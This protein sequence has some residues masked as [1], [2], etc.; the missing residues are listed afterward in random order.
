[1]PTR[2]VRLA[3]VRSGWL[4]PLLLLLFAGA[5]IASAQD[6]NA[7]LH[8]P[9]HTSRSSASLDPKLLRLKWNAPEGFS[10]PLIIGDT[11]Y[12]V[13]FRNSGTGVGDVA[14]FD[15]ESGAIKWR[16]P[17]A[18][19]PSALAFRD[20]RLHFFTAYNATFNVISAAT[21]A[22]DYTVP[23]SG[24]WFVDVPTL[25][26]RPGGGD[27]IAL[28]QFNSLLNAVSVGA[29]SGSILWTK[30]NDSGG[31]ATSLSS[32]RLVSAGPGHY[33]TF[34][35]LTGDSTEFR[36]S[37][38]SGPYGKGAVVDTA[39]QQFYVHESWG[40]APTYT[41]NVIS[42]YSYA[43]ATGTTT[44]TLLWQNTLDPGIGRGLALG[45][46]G[47]LYTTSSN[48]L[49]ELAPDTGSILRSAPL[50][51]LSQSNYRIGPMLSDGYVW[52]RNNRSITAFALDTLTP[53][54]T[55]PLAD[56][57]RPSG[58][59]IGAI[60]DRTLLVDFGPAS[61]QGFAVYTAPEP[62]SLGAVVL[63][64]LALYPRARRSRAQHVATQKSA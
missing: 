57:D 12:A 39:R 21:G 6:W 59:S 50:S 47:K 20:G 30:S 19:G 52:V 7:Y 32:S 34:D 25:V 31:Q 3:N 17:T 58:W 10:R 1:M 43:G 60:T 23:V 49:F 45:A 42:A 26:D 38:V 22:T 55:I 8:D 2:A 24:G 15:L 13:D 4:S 44:P 14:A 18:G 16:V 35:V 62:G 9:Q 40:G 36:T 46:D 33:R 11:V 63:A 37:P 5:S 28:L 51:D 53:I 56:D 48:T 54:H 29:A 64:V 41:A 61:F 27:P